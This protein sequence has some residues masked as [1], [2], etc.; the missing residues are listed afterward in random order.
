MNKIKYQLDLGGLTK[1]AAITKV[2]DE[3]VKTF[4]EFHKKKFS[5]NKA[6]LPDI[7]N[8]F[9]GHKFDKQTFL[10]SNY[11][12]MCPPIMHPEL[13]VSCAVEP[14]LVGYGIPLEQGDMESIQVISEQRFKEYNK[15]NSGH[16]DR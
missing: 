15:I 16:F 2:A 11:Y 12:L 3:V 6:I 5:S 9:V 10:R 8:R 7:V 1:V 4:F 14:I 13:V